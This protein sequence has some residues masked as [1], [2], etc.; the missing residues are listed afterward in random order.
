MWATRPFKAWAGEKL[1]AAQH[2]LPVLGS[3]TSFRMTLKN[4]S[5]CNK[6]KQLQFKSDCNSRTTTRYSL[7]LARL[8]ALVVRVASGVKCCQP[9]GSSSVV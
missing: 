1:E 3:F 2:I 6:Q 4:K 9:R 5:N 7:D 8:V